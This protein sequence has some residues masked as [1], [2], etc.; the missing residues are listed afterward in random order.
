MVVVCFVDLTSSTIQ[1][2]VSSGIVAE[3]EFLT[4]PVNKVQTESACVT[5]NL[6]VS[7][8]PHN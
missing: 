5:V 4:T 6:N 8:V 2:S 1:R 7:I 3:G